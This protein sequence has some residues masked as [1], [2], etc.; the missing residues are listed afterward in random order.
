MA[1]Y[2]SNWVGIDGTK[3]DIE[4]F[5]AK[6]SKPYTYRYQNH[7]D[8]K[9]V[10]EEFDSGFAFWN[11]VR[12]ADEDLDIYFGRVKEENPEG[13]DTWSDKKKMEHRLT[14]SGKNSY[15]W[16]IRNWGV[17]HDI[18]DLTNPSEVEVSDD[19]KKASVNYT[20]ETKWAIPE[21]AFRAMVEQHPELSFHFESEEEQGWGAEYSGDKGVFTTIDEWDIP[22]THEEHANREKTCAC[23]WGDDPHDWYEDCPEYD[24]ALAE[25]HRENGFEACD[26]DEADF[27]EPNLIY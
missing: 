19:G 26:C 27:E 17:S 15:D 8:N 18:W 25:S 7:E 14:F 11:F 9:E 21:H 23:E 2:V 3:E 20:F 5:V 1:N 6:A 12:P 13:F 16:N 4:A 22:E 10:V 24:E